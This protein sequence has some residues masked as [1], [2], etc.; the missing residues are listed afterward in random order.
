[1]SNST[2]TLTSIVQ[3][4]KEKA[5]KTLYLVLKKKPLSVKT[6]EKI[7]VEIEKKLTKF[8][9]KIIPKLEEIKPKDP[10]KF[11]KFMMLKATLKILDKIM[12]ENFMKLTEEDKIAA[13]NI[14]E[15]PGED[16][17]EERDD[18]INNVQ[19]WES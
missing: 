9:D 7:N 16:D 11:L 5:K 8:F 4:A 1:M 6:L 19:K 18:M 12:E 15:S 10:E 17:F 2:Y 14:Y 13:K 3:Y